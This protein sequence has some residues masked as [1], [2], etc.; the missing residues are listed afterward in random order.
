MIKKIIAIAFAGFLLSVLYIITVGLFFDQDEVG[1]PALGLKDGDVS[2]A[3]SSGSLGGNN[4]NRSIQL[5]LV[6]I[7]KH[8]TQSDCWLLINNK[9]YSVASYLTAHPGGRNT[10]LA[11]CGKEASAVF[12]GLPHSQNA[13]TLLAGYYIGDFGQT[14]SIQLNPQGQTTIPTLP[15]NNTS[16]RDREYDDD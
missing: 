12:E 7:A 8:N 10:I 11:Y 9:V 6:E 16:G 13:H 14:S 1:L 15:Q 5:T 4:F 2:S 3:S